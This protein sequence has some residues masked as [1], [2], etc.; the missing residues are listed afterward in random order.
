LRNVVVFD[1]TGGQSVYGRENGTVAYSI[2]QS[3]GQIV[4]DTD[5][6]SPRIG[7]EFIIYTANNNTVLIQTLKTGG[8]LQISGANENTSNLNVILGVNTIAYVIV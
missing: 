2:N 4:L 6:T 7:T 8:R 5:M 3:P 1:D